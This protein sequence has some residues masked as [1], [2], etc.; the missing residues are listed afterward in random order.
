MRR[1]Y[2]GSS[3][4]TRI[5]AHLCPRCFGDPTWIVPNWFQCVC[6]ALLVAG[7]KCLAS[8]PICDSIC[9]AKFGAFRHAFRCS[10]LRDGRGEARWPLWGLPSASETSQNM[11]WAL[12]VCWMASNWASTMSLSVWNHCHGM[13]MFR[14]SPCQ[15]SAGEVMDQRHFSIVEITTTH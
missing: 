11:L 6:S 7:Q 2:F 1:P 14:F 3:N 9:I 4:S 15:C 10:C 12:D 8:V 5:P 13:W